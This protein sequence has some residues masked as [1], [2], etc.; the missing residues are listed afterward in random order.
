MK[1]RIIT[2]SVLAAIGLAVVLVA[3]SRRVA[4]VRGDAFMSANHLEEWCLL[5]CS[6]TLWTNDELK[7]SWYVGY[8]T[9]SLTGT[10]PYVEVSVFGR[11]L[12]SNVDARGMS[13]Q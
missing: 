7:P 13:N 11:V 6:P 1:R 12:R 9:D 5:R 3:V 2:L 4:I 10:P 8:E